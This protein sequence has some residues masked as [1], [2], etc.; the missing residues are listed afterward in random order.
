MSFLNTICDGVEGFATQISPDFS[1]MKA[2]VEH[3]G[4]KVKNRGVIGLITGIALAILGT[5]LCATT[6][7]VSTLFGIAMITSSLLFFYLGY[8]N[9]KLGENIQEMSQK[10]VQTIKDNTNERA[11]KNSLGKGTICFEW[12]IN[13]QVESLFHKKT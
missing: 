10:I 2:E 6:G 8:N 9:L 12:E 13:R 4:H 3:H 7:S 5:T 11:F 1:R